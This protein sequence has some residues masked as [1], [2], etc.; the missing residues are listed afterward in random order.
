MYKLNPLFKQIELKYMK[1]AI[2]RYGGL[3]FFNFYSSLGPI[4]ITKDPMQLVL[5]KKGPPVK[6][7][8]CI[9]ANNGDIIG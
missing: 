8:I 6:D 3:F 1:I 5:D 9:F 4:A 2:A 7:F